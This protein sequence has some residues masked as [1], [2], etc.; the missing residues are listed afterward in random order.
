LLII[1]IVLAVAAVLVSKD[2]RKAGI[3][4]GIGVIVS[5]V[6]VWILIARIGAKETDDRPAAAAI[7][8][9]L[10]D[11]LLRALLITALIAATAVIILWYKGSNRSPTL[12]TSDGA[13]LDPPPVEPAPPVD[14][15]PVDLA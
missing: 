5:N 11:S 3:D 7:F 14:P 13:A 12:A 9:V 1:S 2:R 15:P 8:E 10:R 6:I 4:L